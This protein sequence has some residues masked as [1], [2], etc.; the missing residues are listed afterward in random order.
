MC[1][2]LS[3]YFIHLKDPLMPVYVK[4]NIVH[5]SDSAPVSGAHPKCKMSMTLP[6]ETEFDRWYAFCW[7]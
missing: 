1:K 4:Y 2:I 5:M 3:T 6:H 7:L